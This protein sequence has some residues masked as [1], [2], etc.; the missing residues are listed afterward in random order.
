MNEKSSSRLVQDDFGNWYIVPIEELE[1]F[2]DWLNDIYYGIGGYVGREFNE[3]R[4]DGICRLTLFDW[5]IE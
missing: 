5:S 1:E 3:Y 2:T 4:I